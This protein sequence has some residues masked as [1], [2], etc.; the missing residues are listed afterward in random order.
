[1]FGVPQKLFLLRTVIC[2]QNGREV[3]HGEEDTL[4]SGD[5]HFFVHWSSDAPEIVPERVLHVPNTD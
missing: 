5:L 3:I 1:M 2:A 4:Y